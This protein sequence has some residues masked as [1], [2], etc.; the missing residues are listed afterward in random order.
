M[1]SFRDS[2]LR[3][4]AGSSRRRVDLRRKYNIALS[5]HKVL[6]GGFD[7]DHCPL[8]GDNYSK[9]VA[10]LTLRIFDQEM[11]MGSWIVLLLDKQSFFIEPF[12]D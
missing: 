5:K 2:I 4:E 3:L 10:L 7:A 8:C 12:S 11:C 1:R 6:M 9:H